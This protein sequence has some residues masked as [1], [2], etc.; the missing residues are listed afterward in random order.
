MLETLPSRGKNT[1]V[2]I[3]S[4]EFDYEEALSACAQG[5]RRALRSLYDRESPRLL[6]VA[7]RIVR[8]RQ[9]AE[10]V[11]HDAFVNIW[12]KAG[13]F[14]ASRGSGR[15][16]VYSVV[17]HMAL[18][19]VRN[20]QRDVFV[21]DETMERM[22]ADAALD[23]PVTEAYE[24]RANLGRLHDCLTELNVGQR[25]SILHAYVEGRSHGEIART[26]QSPLGTVKTWITRGLAALRE[27]MQ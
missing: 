11:L 5:D 17:R 14:D 19:V 2:A 23:S 9:T 22:A 18:D 25:A 20:G 7:L 24:L 27:C 1:I 16:W 3:A 26:L 6:G 13:T 10:D 8:E 12:T 21:S 4:D 15:G